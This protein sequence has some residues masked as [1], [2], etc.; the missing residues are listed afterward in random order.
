MSNRVRAAGGSG[1]PASIGA[2]VAETVDRGFDWGSAAVG[3]GVGVATTLLLIAL[4]A[5]ALSRRTGSHH[6][7]GSPS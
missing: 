5:V 3:A 1:S 6:Q 7:G 2:A 4:A